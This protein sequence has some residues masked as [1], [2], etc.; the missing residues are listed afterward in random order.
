MLNN[1]HLI[2]IREKLLDFSF[3]VTWVPGKTHYIVNALGRY[4]VFGPHEMGL[5]IDNIA[6]CFSVNKLMLLGDITTRHMLSHLE[7]WFTYFGWPLI[8]RSDNGRQF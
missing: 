4:P 8:I 3:T 2:R 5:P 6:T 7:T 1:Q